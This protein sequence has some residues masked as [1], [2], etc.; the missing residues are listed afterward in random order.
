M[1]AIACSFVMLN[2]AV[3]IASDRGHADRNRG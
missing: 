2:T 3:V 1:R